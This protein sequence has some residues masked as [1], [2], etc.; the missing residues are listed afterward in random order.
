[1]PELVVT[2]PAHRTAGCDHEPD[3]PWA[4]SWTAD[5]RRVCWRPDLAA[6]V[7][8][9]VDAEVVDQPVPAALGRR[10]LVPAPQFWRDWTAA[11]VSAKLTDTPILLW[12]QDHGFTA[13]EG[14]R[15]ERVDDLVISTGHAR[16]NGS[17]R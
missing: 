3:R 17:G 16:V 9:A 2:R 4:H 5:G 13:L 1:M 8:I 10:H 6:P 15:T 12:L 14:I 7:R 11:E